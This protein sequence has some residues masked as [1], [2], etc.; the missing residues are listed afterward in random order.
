MEVVVNAQAYYKGHSLNE[1]GSVNLSMKLKYDNLTN[2][3]QLQ[4]MLN[5]DVN[6]AVKIPGA[7][8]MKLGMFRIKSTTI[9]G[10]GES[11]V[12]FNGLN[13]YIEVDNLNN[14]V[15]KEPFKAK[16]VAEVEQEDDESE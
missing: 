13:D 16:F 9:N 12:K 14:L 6:I 3:I 11:V 7:K 2:A 1:N 5:N 10:D 4:Q 8:A 15:T